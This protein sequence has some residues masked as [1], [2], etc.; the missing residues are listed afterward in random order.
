MTRLNRQSENEKKAEAAG[1]QGGDKA[2]S[3][4][5][6]VS[7]GTFAWNSLLIQ[8]INLSVILAPGFADGAK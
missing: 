6:R 3:E 2:E 7:L 5:R 4:V 1:T 8:L